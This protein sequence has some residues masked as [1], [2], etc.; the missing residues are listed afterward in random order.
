MHDDTRY[1]IGQLQAKNAHLEAI[2]VDLQKQIDARNAKEI[3]YGQ[4][5]HAHFMTPRTAG[6]KTR[7]DELDDA[8]G[9]I[10]AMILLRKF[11]LGAATFLTGVGAAFM[12]AKGW[13]GK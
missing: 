7:A 3:L 8:L 4:T 2:I 5:V 12:L 1:A 11:I 13:L 10:R 6:G 9:V